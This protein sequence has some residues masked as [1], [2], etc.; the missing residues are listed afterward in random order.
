MAY[1]TLCPML[2]WYHHR[3][4]FFC[5]AKFDCLFLSNVILVLNVSVVV[6]VAIT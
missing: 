2:S 5:Q 4:H 1:F 6:V 3:L